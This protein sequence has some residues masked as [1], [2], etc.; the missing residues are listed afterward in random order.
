VPAT[1]TTLVNRRVRP[2]FG[3][4]TRK[5][6]RCSSTHG[7]E[8]QYTRRMDDMSFA[9]AATPLPIRL[10]PPAP[11]TDAESLEFS[12]LNG[13]LRIQQEPNGDLTGRTPIGGRTGKINFQIS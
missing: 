5:R 9:I 10:T 3:P 7:Y 13:A 4:A 11:M 6:Q 1:V 8:W 12:A 2:D